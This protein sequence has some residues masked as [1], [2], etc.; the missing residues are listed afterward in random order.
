VKLLDVRLATLALVFLVSG[1]ALVPIWGTPNLP[2]VDYPNHLARMYILAQDG[3][4]ETLNQFYR[5]DW[6]ILPNL[7]MDFVTPFLARAIGVEA[8]GKAF[9]SMT[10]LVFLGGVVALHYSI[11]RRYSAWPFLSAIL[12][13]NQSFLWGFVNYVFGTG[14]AFLLAA[15]WIRLRMQRIAWLVFPAATIV[16]FF[17]H[18]VSFGIYLIIVFGYECSILLGGGCKFREVLRRGGQI[19][20]QALPALM[21]LFFA[22]PTGEG[23][24][25]TSPFFD[26]LGAKISSLPLIVSS[27][28]SFVDF[29]LTFLPLLVFSVLGLAIGAIKINRQMVVPLLLMVFTYFALPKILMSSW[30]AWDRFMVPLFMI[31]IASTNWF[32]R[33]RAAK[34][35]LGCLVG[36]V[37]L[38]RLWLLWLVWQDINGEFASIREVAARIPRGDSLYPL[39]A[40]HG[41]YAL[42]RRHLATMAIIDRDAFVPTLFANPTQ[43]PVSFSPAALSLTSDKPAQAPFCFKGEEQDWTQALRYDYVL[44]IDAPS[45]SRVL[46]TELELV[47]ASNYASLYKVARQNE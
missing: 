43:Q 36:L 28:D 10:F 47:M 39:D 35:A 7:A 4:N 42:Y 26:E 6:K 41:N 19:A 14:V 22:S 12:L 11:H 5:V 38:G 40:C 18:A 15:G 31:A 1:I 45:D 25:H 23:A 46:P 9:L 8:A 24:K 30:Y 21:I 27:Y 16:L 37:F 17:L 20:A 3:G 13:Y 2:L 32:I 33:H 34:I 44:L 29:K